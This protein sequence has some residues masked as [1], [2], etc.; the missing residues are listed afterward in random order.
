MEWIVAI[1]VLA[2]IGTF[3]YVIYDINNRFAH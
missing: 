1:A 3:A 2:L